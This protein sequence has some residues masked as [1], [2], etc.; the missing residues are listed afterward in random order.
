MHIQDVHIKNFRLLT[1]VSLALEEQATV[2]VG[3]NNSGKTSLSEIMRRLLGE[4][5]TSFRLE[6]FST[7]SYGRFCA[8]LEARNNGLADEEVRSQLPAIELRVRVKY[9]AARPELGPLSPFVIDLDPACTEALIVMRYELKDGQIGALLD[10][11]PTGAIT[12]ESRVTFFKSLRERIPSTFGMKLWAEDPNDATNRRALPPAAV[13][14]VI[15][16]GFIN[17][18]RGLDDVTSR[19]SDVLAKT[20][21]N[22]FASASLPGADSSDKQV[23]DALTQA[24]QGI[25]AQIDSDFREQLKS[26]VPAL[27]SFGYPGLSGQELQTET[28]LDVRKLLSNFTKIRYAGYS[29]VSLPEGYNG[30]GARNLI[31][32]LFQLASF[33]KAFR[34]E[35]KQPTVHLIF[36]EEPEAHL[37]PQ[38]Q[39]VFIRQLNKIAHRLVASTT[40]KT[41]WPVQF[42]VSTHSSHIANEVGFE[43]IRYFLSA[44]IP[45]EPTG[46][47]QT[48]IKDLRQGLSHTSGSTREFLHQYLTLTRCDLFF[49]DKAIL[50]EGLSE[51][52]LLPVVIE[53][54][55]KSEPETP[56][57]SAQ[58]VTI[59]EVGGAYAHLFSDLLQFL[60]LRSLV[61][62]DL[63]AVEKPG[64]EA[65]AVHKGTHSSNACLR[66]W[67]KADPAFSLAGL[68][69]KTEG[70][71]IVNGKRIA[72]QCPEDGTGAC[73][74][75]FEDAF[76][77]ANPALF[78]LSATSPDDRELEARSKAAQFKK[79]EFALKYAIADKDWTTPRYIVEGV[80]WLAAGD[81]PAPDPGLVLAAASV[82]V[83]AEPLAANAGS[84]PSSTAAAPITA[85]APSAGP[86][87]SA[88]AAPSGNPSS[89]NFGSDDVSA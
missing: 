55:E 49:A 25:Q 14:G 74:R 53:K 35:E 73:G 7:A 69:S 4:G 83:P 16:T 11:Q 17:A 12:D 66:A 21:E 38:M 56:S 33:Y 15:K 2:I 62:T 58:Y 65:C 57:L 36:I 89:A 84:G 87:P 30:L 75:T 78:K 64:G 41:P 40:E 34:A 3:R 29:G 22:L 67:F 79:S 45:G 47:R 51:R 85:A 77:L 43:T 24:V 5:A 59:M 13:H 39:E 68:R 28:L 10:G 71:K 23:A 86:A 80:R 48:K 88:A 37:H 61:I 60:E 32:I 44:S 42:I 81:N 9:D 76:I 18:Q 1:D 27:K 72:Y 63:D 54:L 26:L 50:V 20:V 52:L 19:E 82:I 6:D 31:F 70:E 8:A 46:I